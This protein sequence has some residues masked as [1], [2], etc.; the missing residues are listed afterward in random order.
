MNPTEDKAGEGHPDEE[1]IPE[2]TDVSDNEN[3]SIDVN[4]GATGPE[5]STGETADN[6]DEVS[7]VH[8]AASEFDPAT[9][10]LE[11]DDDVNDGDPIESLLTD[12]LA[13]QLSDTAPSTSEGQS[14]DTADREAEPAVE[15]T[16]SG[17]DVEENAEA[18]QAE[19]PGTVVDPA[20]LLEVVQQ[21]RKRVIAV[22]FATERP[23]QVK[24]TEIITAY[25]G[26]LTSAAVANAVQLTELEQLASE[27]DACHAAALVNEKAEAAANSECVGQETELYERLFT[28]LDVVISVVDEEMD[29]RPDDTEALQDAPD[30]L[31]SRLANYKKG[32]GIIQRMLNKVKDRKKDLS[33]TDQGEVVEEFI[34]TAPPESWD[35][36]AAWLDELLVEFHKVRDA[37]Y[38]A[39]H[40]VKKRVENCSKAAQDTV[41]SLISAIDGIDSGLENEPMTA[42]AMA[43][44]RKQYDQLIDGWLGAYESLSG[45]VEQFLENSGVSAYVVEPGTPFDPET[46]EPQGVVENLELNNDEVASVLRRGFSLNGIQIR[47][48]Q[49]DVVRNN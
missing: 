35:A 40:D 24:A 6:V 2:S 36:V 20:A 43:Q 10:D 34:A 21:E 25:T 27:V 16:D 42:A 33:D 29:A 28:E 4:T 1:V 19:E 8:D 14:P 18:L 13:G 3:P 45:A 17:A 32:I 9:D 7:P 31:R 49:V 37:N 48:V 11:L 41:K 5:P 12:D 30:E 23:S 39:I 38:H 44:H 47:P 22:V 46:M 15:A 26:A